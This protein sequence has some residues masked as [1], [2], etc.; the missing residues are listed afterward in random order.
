MRS[1]LLVL[2]ALCA[3]GTLAVLPPMA[4]A[5]PRHNLGLTITVA[6]PG[7]ISAGERVLIYG[8]LQGSGVSDQPIM[9]YHRLAG[10]PFFTLVQ[11]TSTDRAGFYEFPRAEGVV[12]TNRSW[13]VRG[14]HG[15]HSRTIH[16]RVAALVS[17]TASASS[18][19]SG[20][21]V[22]FTGHVTPDH[23]FEPVLLQQ[24]RSVGGNGWRTVKSGRTGRGSS[25]TIER[26]WRR[27]G[28]YTLR[29]YF[30]G[31]RRNVAGES[32]DVTVIV[33]QRQVPSFTITSSKPVIAY[34]SAVVIG[35]VLRQSGGPEPD[36]SV[37]LLGQ[38][39]DSPP[40]AIA[41]TTT[42]PNGAYSFTV[43]PS[44]NTAYHVIRTLAPH[45][46][47]AVLYEGVSD[48]VS[49]SAAPTTVQIGQPVTFTGTVLPGQ[50]GH[51]VY[52][53]RQDANGSWDNVAV[54]ELG[55]SSSYK[56]T[57][58][59]ARA[60]T[61]ELRVRIY[62]GPANVGAASAAVAI[63]VTSGVAPPQSLPPAS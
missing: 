54:R 3:A 21:R 6:P 47:S 62:G 46:H 49:V 60:G 18:I 52:L 37:T 26:A 10:A 61:H 11:R 20:Q 1:R 9:L 53:Q 29:A 19:L 42:Q 35:G 51:P 13:F 56:F 63:T 48:V 17:L 5:H 23:P 44:R 41:T 2:A 34:G 7:Q 4:T 8:R 50:A 55:P 36:T 22:S 28:V 16:E 59:F 38:T 30:P 15:T 45:R 31:D 32:D 14:P 27:P 25:F 43:S 57:R 24:Q 39:V 33:Q 58:A 40:Q 12:M